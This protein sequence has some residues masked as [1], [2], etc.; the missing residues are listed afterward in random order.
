MGGRRAAERRLSLAGEPQSAGTARRAVGQLLVETG[1]ESWRDAAELAVTEV[2]TNAVLH[3]QTRLDL[4]VWV[5]AAGVRVEVRDFSPSL[6]RPRRYAPDATTGRGLALVAGVTSA[7][8]VEQLGDA[9]KVVWFC[10]D[11]G[12]AGRV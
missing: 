5:D 4:S 9:G 12:S 1:H 6:P 3:A 7:F 2:V 11:D 10:V 8:G